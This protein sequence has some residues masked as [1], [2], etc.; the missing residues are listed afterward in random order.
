MR[1]NILSSLSLL[2][3]FF[4]FSFFACSQPGGKHKIFHELTE[5]SEKYTPTQYITDTTT[6]ASAPK[7]VIFFIGDGMGPAQLFAALT[8]NGGDLYMKQMQVLGMSQTQS[9]SDYVTDSAAGGTA[10]SS[11]ERT[12]NGMI[13]MRPDSTR[14]TSMLELSERAG[15]AT[16][17]VATVVVT[18]ATPASFI[19][20]VP[21]RNMYEEIATFYPKS[22]IDIFIGGGK[23]HF[24]ERADGRNLIEEMQ[25]EGYRFYDDIAT[26]QGDKEMKQAILAYPES[27]P[28]AAERK[29][30]LPE[31]V[32]KALDV[33]SRSENG[34]FVMVEG[35]QIDYG[36]H[37]NN[38]NKVVGEAL[39]MDKALGVAL[40][41]AARDRETLV[42]VT[43][44]HETGGLVLHGGDMEKGDLKAT[45]STRG[46]S[47][48]M[49]PVYAVGPG[50][51]AFAG[52]YK[53]TEVFEK[54][55]KALKLK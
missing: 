38:L 26:S 51:E 43:A 16:G 52:I 25:T 31:Y 18:H 13:G 9:A 17:L 40:E 37:E 42:V 33:L 8:A 7:N 4:S 39:D 20:H 19:A 54:I 27:A 53:N 2:L 11:G 32:G 3:F 46:H 47:A 45:F 5:K 14:M 50:A 29:E 21:D 55:V 44:D 24:T 36:G 28:V 22:G 34:F 1:T 41:F 48:V 49:V 15:K 23:K 10:L 30:S 35:S 12:T 6:F